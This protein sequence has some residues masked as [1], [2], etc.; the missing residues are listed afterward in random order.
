MTIDCDFLYIGGG[1]GGLAGVVRAADLGL[2][3]VVVE[4][5]PLLGGVA[6]YSAG[7]TWVPA[8]HL[9]G[10]TDRVEDAPRYMAHLCADLDADERTRA[11]IVA[12]APDVFRYLSDEVGIPLSVIDGYNAA[13]VRR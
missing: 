3:V 1:L 13:A 8:N 12:A 6:S 7:H 5:S 9:G 4:K 11:D 2:D 10:G